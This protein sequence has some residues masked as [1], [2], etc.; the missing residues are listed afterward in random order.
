MPII[1]ETHNLARKQEHAR[2]IPAGCN[3]RY[4]D[5]INRGGNLNRLLSNLRN[6]P[7]CVGGCRIAHMRVPNA[8]AANVS[9]YGY[10]CV[11]HD[12]IAKTY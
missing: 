2:V 3:A 10:C 5:R 4:T 8:D 1:S 11:R 12:S 6:T 9:G 7:D